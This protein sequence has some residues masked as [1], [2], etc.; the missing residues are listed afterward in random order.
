MSNQCDA[1]SVGRYIS[2]PQAIQMIP[3][4]FDGN[5][6]ELHEFVQNVQSTYEVVDPLDHELLFKFVC[7]KVACEA[8]SK[9]LARMHWDNWE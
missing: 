4:P 6:T 2:L 9:L 3:K 1:G 8:K 7:A 5:P